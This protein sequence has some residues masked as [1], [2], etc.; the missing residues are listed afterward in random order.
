[1]ILMTNEYWHN[2][3]DVGIKENGIIAVNVS[4]A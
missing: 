1:M 2:V 4:V 3:L